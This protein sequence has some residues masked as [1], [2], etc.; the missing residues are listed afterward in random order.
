LTREEPGPTLVEEEFR[1]V[2]VGV[3]GVR[4][5]DASVGS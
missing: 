1:K 3:R 4:G 2:D 5:G